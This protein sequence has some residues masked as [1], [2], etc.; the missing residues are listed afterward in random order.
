MENNYGEQTELTERTEQTEQDA[1]TEQT[2]QTIRT[3]SIQRKANAYF[4]T[5]VVINLLLIVLGGL[6]ITMFL[7]GMQNRTALAKQKESNALA[8][9]EAVS[10]LERN[11]ENADTLT[12]IYHEGNW[13]ILDDVE[14]LF[15]KGLFDAMESKDSTIWADVFSDIVSRTNAKYLFLLN[16]DGTIAF[17]DNA[18]LAGINPAATGHLTQENVNKLL[19]GCVRADGAIEPILVKNQ[20]GTFYFYSKEYMHGNKRYMLAVGT[21]SSVLNVQVESLRDISAVLRRMAVIN[22][23]FLFGVDS[24]DGL[25]SYYKNGNELLTGQKAENTGLSKEAFKDGYNGT[26]TING[27]KYY[28]STRTFENAVIIAAS[29]TD[30]VLSHDRYVLFWSILGFILVMIL[31]LVYAVIVRNDFVRHAVETQRVVLRSHSS[32]PIYFDKS[33]FLK[34]F[35]LMLLGVLV[36]FGISF[37]TQTLLEITEGI[38]R[39]NVALQEVKGR[40]DQSQENRAVIEDYYNNWFLSTAKMIAFIVEEDPAVLN[41]DSDHYHS[42]YD[43]E[44]NRVFLLDEEGNRIKSVSKSA[45]LQELCDR[46]LIDAIY[47]FDE[48]GRTIAT[49]TG[50]WFFVLSTNEGDQSYPFRQVLDGKTDQYVQTAMVN[51]LG[52]ETQY[53]GVTLHYYTMTDEAGNTVYVNRY[54]YEAAKAGDDSF[55]GK[56]TPHSSLLQIELDKSLTGEILEPTTPESVLSTDMLG[57]GAIVMFDTTDAHTCLYS[58]SSA[59]IGKSA[60]ELGISTR[61]FSGSDYYGFTRVNGRS[62]FQFF[63]YAE[64]YFIATAIPK[65][66]MFTTRT[67]IA[68]ATAGV[69]LILILILS[70]TVTVTNKEEETMYETM[71]EEQGER[72]LNSAIYSIILPSGRRATTVQAKARWDNRRIPWVERSPEQKL[73]TMVTVILAFLLA[74]LILSAIGVGMFG[75]GSSIVR[76][77]LSGNWD[78]NLNIFAISACALVLAAILIAVELFRIPVQ[79]CTVL[80]GTRGETVGHLLLSVIKYGSAIAAVFYCLHLLGIDSA[81]LLASA[82]ILSLVIGFGAQ[83]LIKDIIAGIFIV[84]EGEFRVGDIVT[85]SSFRGTVVDIGLRTTKI[86][87]MDGNIK[88]FNNSDISGV[89]NMTKET[90]RAIAT[91]DMEYGQDI[92]YVEAVLA[93]ELPK[94]KEKN[95]KILDGPDYY[96]IK[97]LGESGVTIMVGCSCIEQDVIGV[98]RY[99]NRE[100]LQIFYRNG[101]NVPFPNVTISNLDTSGRKTIDDLPPVDEDPE[102][103]KEDEK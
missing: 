83:S 75:R 84:F 93:R 80:L 28:C 37:Y 12:E 49:N 51:E 36:M 60:A 46:N 91:I 90:S 72:G 67:G 43:E 56:I 34:V 87:A 86:M 5:K 95:E 38:E 53:F 21:D 7:N 41:A 59:M 61:A 44:G 8:L 62:F 48:N 78:R 65:A 10:I 18:E 77:I 58:P 13:K 55:G 97:A 103:Q 27:V 68:L 102:E 29:R 4:F 24:S 30:A 20:Y 45:L 98:S 69:C 63:Q 64:D 88:I 89:L 25:F 1:Q 3:E 76:Y 100:L 66:G 9:N 73:G 14:L 39:S 17:A 70:L 31:C 6:G 2:E 42:V 23:G 99:L 22:E 96:G 82:G 79:L 101:I 85:I 33:V 94:L 40:Y 81:S 52:E 47:L 32:N 19:E 50:N 74:Y 71:S 16:P 57:G 92:D 35:P 15:S 26:E 11:E 54:M